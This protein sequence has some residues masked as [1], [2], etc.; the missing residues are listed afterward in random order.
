MKHILMLTLLLT[1][2]AF[3]VEFEDI[4]AKAKAGRPMYQ[5]LLGS[6]Y[7]QG[8]GIPENDA[9][10]VKWYRKAAEQGDAIAQFSLSYMYDLG[11]GIP[12]ND[13][14]AVKWIRKAAEQNLVAAQFFLGAKYFLG[15]GV[16]E[17]HIKAY[18]WSS[19]AKTNGDER[20]KETLG[21]LKTEMTK[22]QIAEAQK[23]AAK[24]YESNYKDC[25]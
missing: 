25:D 16:P 11:E 18:V 8:E 13:A 2:G 3:A 1:S 4:L 21:F 15:E 10:A 19:M 14:E 17:N 20:A 24:C 9:E 7:D 5:Y 23:L 22:N 12:E 6:M